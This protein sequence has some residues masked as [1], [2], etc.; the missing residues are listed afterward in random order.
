MN[1]EQFQAFC[2]ELKSNSPSPPNFDPQLESKMI[3][4]MT[5]L[6]PRRRFWK[7]TLVAAGFLVALM[8]LGG[9]IADNIVL[10]TV[11]E[12]PDGTSQE[13]SESLLNYWMRHVHDHARQI[14]RHLHGE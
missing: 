14:H 5:T 9:V 13:E 1:D 2:N 4:E 3:R 12:Q 6:G 8:T 10:A 11:V 7:K